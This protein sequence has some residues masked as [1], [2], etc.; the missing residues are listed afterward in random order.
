MIVCHTGSSAEPYGTVGMAEVG[1]VVYFIRT[2]DVVN[3]EIAQDTTVLFGEMTGD[4]AACISNMLHHLVKPMTEALGVAG[5][6]SPAHLNDFVRSL[7]RLA[8]ELDDTSKSMT[9]SPSFRS[10]ALFF[11]SLFFCFL[12]FSHPSPFSRLVT[13]FTPLPLS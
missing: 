2:A 6:S 11:F 1:R 10:F 3:A 13:R 4:P 9:V 12:F 5:K 7:G 8:Q